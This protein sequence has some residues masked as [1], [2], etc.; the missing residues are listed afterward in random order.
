MNKKGIS[1]TSTNIR[2]DSSSTPQ[3]S[4][5][6]LPSFFVMSITTTVDSTLSITSPNPLFPSEKSSSN[7]DV[8][9]AVVSE[10]VLLCATKEE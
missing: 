5:P 1:S 8:V 7:R 6:E 2:G 3:A 10:G 9:A 4:L